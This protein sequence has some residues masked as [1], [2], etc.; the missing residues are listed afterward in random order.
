ML[1]TIHSI[2]PVTHDVK[3]F[4]FEKPA[5]YHFVPGQATDVSINKPEWKEEL[6]TIYFHFSQ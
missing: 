2:E 5:N 1:V 3:R 4:R 6:E